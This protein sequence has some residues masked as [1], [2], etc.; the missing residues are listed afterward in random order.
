MLDSLIFVN[1]DS[2]KT[3][4]DSDELE[5]EVKAHAVNQKD[6]VI[7][8]GRLSSSTPMIGEL[9][10]IV[11]SVGCNAQTSFKVGDRVCGFGGSSYQTRSRINHNLVQRIPDSMTFAQGASFPYAFQTAYHALVEIANLQHDG[12]VLIHSALSS[13]GMA[14]I[15]GKLTCPLGFTEKIQET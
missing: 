2:A 4:L 6:V 1:D 3:P 12:S 8:M 9:S 14:A 10:G 11:T 7:A 15:L 13:V 5:V